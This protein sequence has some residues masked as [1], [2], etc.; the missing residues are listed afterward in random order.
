M[1]HKI[2]TVGSWDCRLVFCIC[3]QVEDAE[4]ILA[5]VFD[6]DDIPDIK[7]GGAQDAGA[8]LYYENWK[9]GVMWLPNEPKTPETI[10]LLAHEAVHAANHILAMSGVE[11]QE[12]RPGVV[13]DEPW[14]YL[15]QDIVCEFLKWTKG[16]KAK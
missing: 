9:G 15:V 16:I 2:H 7:I 6:S 14:A 1:K 3:D 8:F 10:S 11:F 12:I 13:N 5:E 4:K